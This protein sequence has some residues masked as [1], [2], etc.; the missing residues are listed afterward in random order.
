[1]QVVRI[2]N[3]QKDLLIGEKWNDEA[4]FNPTLDADNEWFVSIQEVYGCDKPEFKWLRQCELVIH[5]PIVVNFP[6]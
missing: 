2:S 5:N 4:F 6:I 1:M 3:E